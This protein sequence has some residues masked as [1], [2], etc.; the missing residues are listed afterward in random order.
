MRVEIKKLREGA[1]IPQ[2]QTPLSAG[3]DA[4]ALLPAP[5]TIK[6][7][8]QEKIPT[9]IAVSIPPGWEMQVRPRS[10]L[11]AKH[12]L[13]VTNSPGTVDADYLNEL[14]ILLLNLGEHPFVVNNGDRIAQLVMQKVS[15]AEFVLVDEFTDT[16]K[17]R[18]GGFGSTG[19]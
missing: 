7:G 3:M 16:A 19:V 11:A 4:H 14:F 18:G 15:Q 1:L 8:S 9:G 17:D 6:P 13:T 5:V 10:G 12:I 2:Y